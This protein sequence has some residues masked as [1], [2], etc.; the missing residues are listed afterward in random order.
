MAISQTRPR[1]LPA[2]IP[3][4]F[5]RLP[6]ASSCFIRRLGEHVDAA[7]REPGRCGDGVAEQG[8]TADDENGEGDEQRE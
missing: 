6:A 4:A 8:K 1:S 2:T 7:L 3:I 5:W